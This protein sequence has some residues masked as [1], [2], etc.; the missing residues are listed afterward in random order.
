MSELKITSIQAFK[1]KTK[2]G[3]FIGVASVVFNDLPFSIRISIGE[4]SKGM[5]AQ[6]PSYKVNEEY[7]DYMFFQDFELKKTV[8]QQI[9][10]AWK[11][12]AGTAKASAPASA[13]N[14]RPAAAKATATRK[15]QPAPNFSEDD[16]MP[17]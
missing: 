1:N 4:N 15:A 3:P 7:K 10:D 16:D 5:Y 9:I 17:F 12:D 11:K 13:G 2:I 6:W 8:S 14:S